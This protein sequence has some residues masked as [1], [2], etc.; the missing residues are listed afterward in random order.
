MK[1]ANLLSLIVFISFFYMN[2]SFL[3]YIKKNNSTFS[4]AIYGFILLILAFT[5][6]FSSDFIF[7]KF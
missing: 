3:E 4:T 5:Q 6:Y 1:C 2:E 7:T